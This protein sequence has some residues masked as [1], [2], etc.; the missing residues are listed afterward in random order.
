ME[1]VLF[2]PFFIL[3]V[4]TVHAYGSCKWLTEGENT[5]QIRQKKKM[6]NSSYLEK[7]S[8]KK[9]LFRWYGRK[10]KVITWSKSWV[11]SLNEI[12]LLKIF[13]SY[14]SKITKLSGD[15]T[16]RFKHLQFFWLSA[17]NFGE[18]WKPL[19]NVM[20]IQVQFIHKMCIW[21]IQF[22]LSNMDLNCFVLVN[23]LSLHPYASPIKHTKF[24]F[25]LLNFHLWQFY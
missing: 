17:S 7:P 14:T 22:I 15:Y 21:A 25:F 9:K 8:C 18:T 12:H 5:R 20:Y 10:V 16:S 2:L 11:L 13:R 4:H 3:S 19:F 23:K 6:R 24:H 1:S